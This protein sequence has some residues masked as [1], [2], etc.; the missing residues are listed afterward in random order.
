MN[1]KF[2]KW[3][4]RILMVSIVNPAMFVPPAA[5]RD[6]A[7]FSGLLSATVVTV[8]PNVLFVIDTSDSMNL[9]EAWKE[10][11]GA[12]DSHVEYLWND[13]TRIVDADA[14]SI[15]E[16][17]AA[18]STRI[19]TQQIPS[20]FFTK[21]GFWDG[22][23]LA[24]RQALW[25]AARTSA[26]ATQIHGTAPAVTDPGPAYQYR[27]YNDLSWIYWL[28]T[29]TA[30]TDPRLRSHSWNKFRG[31]IQE[32][33]DGL[34]GGM[35]R[36]GPSFNDT[37]NYQAYNKCGN[38]LDALTPSTVFVP[39]PIAR[40]TGKYLDQQ[41]AR[42]DPYLATT[43]VGN[44]GYPA[45]STLAI[46]L[47]A[48]ST[49]QY[50]KGY[51]DTTN[52]ATGNP[53]SNPVYRDNT[54]ATADVGLN[55]LPIRYNS[56]SAGS[57]WDGL[58]ADS[59]G[60]ILR[61][62]IDGYATR[63]DLEA[64]MS[65]YALPATSD[66]DGSSI[67]DVKDAK[68]I[69]IKGN[70]DATPAFGSATGL[71][72]YTD[73]TASLC[74]SATG[75]ASA[76]CL[77]KPFGA[78]SPAFTLTKTA[79][80]NLTGTTT[81]KDARA[82]SVKTGGTCTIG[83]ISNS[84]TDTN[85]A[86][87]PSFSD[88]PNP[89]VCPA[90][91]TTNSN[92]YSVD[93]SACAYTVTTVAAAQTCAL[94]GDQTLT[95]GA[96]TPTG[97]SNV[98]I[99]ACA[100]SGP[101]DTVAACAWSGRQTKNVGNCA[102][103]GRTAT[104]SE[105]TKWRA[106]GG[107][108]Q[109]NG[110]TEFCNG[111]AGSQGP[112]ATEADALAS[113][114]G[115]TNTVPAAAYQYGG[116]CTEN[117]SADECSITGASAILGAGYTNVNATCGN[118]NSP[119]AGT[120]THTPTCSENG[121]SSS[122]QLSAGTSRTIRGSTKTY[123]TA[124]NCTNKPNALPTYNQSGSY[125]YGKTCTGT[126]NTCTTNASN[127]FT[128]RGSSYTQ[129]TSCTNGKTPGTYHRGG[130]CTGT[131][132][133]CTQVTPYGGTSVFVS[134]NTWYTNLA[135]CTPPTGAQTYNSN[136]TGTQKLPP[137]DA[138]HTTNNTQAACNFTTNT[139]T[140]L[141]TP[142]TNYNTCTDKSDVNP[143]CFGQFGV[144]CSTGC[145]NATPTSVTG[146]ATSQSHN[147]Y[148]TYDFQAG[149]DYLVHDCKADDGGTKFMHYTSS[150]LNSFGSAWNDTTSYASSAT[151]GVAVDITQKADM[152][153]VNYLNWKFGPKGP[154]GHPIGRKTRLQIAKD[155]LASVIDIYTTDPLFKDKYR[156]GVMAFNQMEKDIPLG[157]ISPNSSG[158][159][160]VKPVKDL[161]VAHGNAIVTSVN[162][163][164]ASS[165][166]P[167]T[168]SL[169]EA[170]RYFKGQSPMFGGPTYQ[171]KESVIST[172]LVP[173]Y[174]TEGVD[175]SADSLT[176]GLYKSPI[177]ATC[178]NNLVILIS[179]GAPENDTSA[180]A[181]ILALPDYGIFSIHQ[182]TG[183][184]QFETISN[185]PYGPTDPI[186]PPAGNNYVL[187]DELSYYMA[188]VD[189]RTDLPGDQTVSLATISYDVNSPVL[190]KAAHNSSGKS[191]KAKDQS[192]LISA[193]GDALTIPPWQPQGGTPASTYNIANGVSGDIYLSA[194]SPTY[195]TVWGGT[196]K[197]Y[198][199]GFGA[200]ECGDSVCGNPNV[201][202]TGNPAI[203][204]ASCGINVEYL[205]TDK[206]KQDELGHDI[207]LRVI[208][209][210]AVS[211]WIPTA[212]PDGPSGVRGGTGQVLIANG[213]PDARKLYT[214]IHGVT[215][216]ASLVSPQNL[217]TPANPLISKT[218][219]GNAAMTD[220]ERDSI[221]SFAQGSDG[222]TTNAWRDW[223][224]FDSLHSTPLVDDGFLYYLTS[225]GVLHSVNTSDGKENWSF[226][227][228]E[229]LSKIAETMT[230][231]NGERLEVADGTPVI[232]NLADGKRYLIF[233]LRRGGRAYYA[234]DITNPAAPALAWKISPTQTCSGNTCS[235]SPNFSELGQAWSTPYVAKIRGRKSGSKFKPALI[236]GAGYDE[237]QDL[238][239]P[240][241][242]TMGR[243]VFVVDAADLTVIKKFSTISGAQ[244]YSVPSDVLAIDTTG[245]AD[246]TIDR[247]YV[248]DMG[249]RLWRMDLDDRSVTNDESNWTIVQIA[250]LA[251][252][253][254]PNKL[255]NRP[256][257]APSIYQ[258]Q[259]FDAVFIGGGDLQQPTAHGT[260]DSGAM[261]MV[262]DYSV[263]K[264]A[265]QPSPIPNAS[266]DFV[267]MTSLIVAA[268]NLTDAEKQ[269]LVTKSGY[270][271]NFNNGEKVSSTAQVYGGVLYFGTYLP[272][273]TTVANLANV[274]GVGGYGKQYVSDALT[275]T[276]LYNDI[277][278]NALFTNDASG[279]VFG[280][281]A[282][283]G[284]SLSPAS[285]GPGK[286]IYL[287]NRGVESQRTGKTSSKM[288]WY[289][290]PEQ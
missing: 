174:V 286:G 188:H 205:E 49:T 151:G 31:Y 267:D 70:R 246:S 92:F 58:K 161:D 28:P 121:S 62:I 259:V 96:C 154:N 231:P 139:V 210:E 78:T 123:Y 128:V 47:G 98:A 109:Q 118:A 84:G 95:I 134:P 168:E 172:A 87:F 40:N 33:G 37:N 83:T 226:M 18:D 240:A 244:G 23:T 173:R 251:T 241:A 102:W 220:A 266:G 125:G 1:A 199:Y 57:G 195:K 278:S 149:T 230:P 127:T 42:W 201:C 254:R 270:V 186:G 45:S 284:V 38:S 64:V 219:L 76:T 192:S 163:M 116:T 129:V 107:T 277:T 24:D 162:A 180:D 285:Q 276:P 26:K 48:P 252:T 32:L 6:T 155:A 97:G 265:V 94:T 233:G 185:L 103:V 238:A 44:S 143:K 235:P 91:T 184:G 65:T 144:N 19:S 73:T 160:L 147:Y 257:M 193:I 114:A 273:Q 43:A 280:H 229:G 234:L 224:H 179:D 3:V 197:K 177:T 115:C 282:G 245:D 237:N 88:V 227:V 35:T 137:G 27:N 72:A 25:Q 209:P 46:A 253:T 214:Y 75:P 140:I 198:K 171:T 111:V 221:L 141:G 167:L 152:Y 176:G 52:P 110:T 61:S 223:A 150:T 146:G 51:L 207:L 113:T 71:H 228:E 290:I 138:A 189:A 166:T 183:S 200:S 2:N 120:Y 126:N 269:A 5:A 283:F 190:D 242:D 217:V 77:D 181:D 159:H 243:A 191:L 131:L 16:V 100:L 236:F 22:A 89:T 279:R 85:G 222:F 215:P 20:Q 142:Y 170:Y 281:V 164:T 268:K 178:Q 135:T 11:A 101:A 216:S 81:S 7:I 130:T 74:D 53:A 156:M 203:T 148:R 211:Y 250:D 30:E 13:L 86:L 194:F 93:N 56:G 55:G 105:S 136:C 264:V 12:Y 63:V 225:D 82:N 117:G 112:F 67:T 248:G 256:T 208:R 41:W 79:T 239:V 133:G 14:G 90:P 249:G 175:T 99:S 213:T 182:P 272:T 255:F 261:F 108:C 153:S 271:I 275:G 21:W 169:Y 202:I 17:T 69:A 59:G 9:P 247:A 104:F 106:S 218:I 132:A 145:N 258:G 260:N 29:G 263:A 34:G 206:T 4:A 196:I 232:A 158:A 39:S 68:F 122:C 80:C 119:P 15:G 187:L 204:Y 54:S 165:A 36:G 50:A 262:K 10:Y 60:F 66:V 288:Y 274:C 289:S 157:S 124:A 212:P 287:R 8:K